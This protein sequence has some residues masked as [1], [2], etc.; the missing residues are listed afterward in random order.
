MKSLIS[1]DELDQLV[2]RAADAVEAAF[3]AYAVDTEDPES[4]RLFRRYVLFSDDASLNAA[5]LRALPEDA[6]FYNRYYCFKKY[7]K[8]Q[9]QARGFDAGLEQQAFSLLESAP[10]LVDWSVIEA[11]EARV[12]AETPKLGGK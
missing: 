5:G 6:I 10:P 2:A 8:R 4:S 1:T 9:E 12:D 7:V 11:I 3:S